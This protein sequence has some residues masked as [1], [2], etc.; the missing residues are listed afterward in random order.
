MYG[1]CVLF[2]L[3]RM[4]TLG[5]IHNIHFAHHSYMFRLPQRSHHQAAHRITK[6]IVY[7]FY[8]NNFLFIILCTAS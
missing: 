8:I 2:K 1:I 5:Q 3:H 7:P 6:K 4:E